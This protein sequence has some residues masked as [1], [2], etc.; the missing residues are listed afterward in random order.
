MKDEDIYAFNPVPPPSAAPAPPAPAPKPR[1]RAWPWV[2]AAL[3]LAALLATAGL[4]VLV[5]QLFD[6]VREGIH[7]QVDGDD[8]EL[9]ITHGLGGLMA[10]LGMA[11]GLFVALLAV[12]LVVPLTLL[13]VALALAL[14]LG[15][16]ALAVAL[17]GAVLLSPLWALLLIVWL[18]VRPGSR[19]RP[20]ATVHA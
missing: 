16:I 18:I 3:L 9:G 19:G 1:R 4:L 17:V 2:L 6:P 12:V 11:A 10:L 13:L 15:G 7:V 5:A 20:A 14:S 8:V